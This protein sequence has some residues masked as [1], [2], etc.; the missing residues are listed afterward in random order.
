MILRDDCVDTGC[1]LK[2]FSK[3]FFL[4]IPFFDGIHR[5]LPALFKACGAKT[6]FVEVDHR[7]RING[8]SKYDTF[9][10]LYRGVMDIIKVLKIINKIKKNRV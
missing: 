2:V 5:F 1:S 3:N 4:S 8:I 6:I 7:Y 10:R 9:G